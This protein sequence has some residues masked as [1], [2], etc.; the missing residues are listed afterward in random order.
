MRK[1][2][3]YLDTHL[4]EIGIIALSI[5]VPLYPK[6]PL[7]DVPHV[8]VYIRLEDFLVAL[9][10]GIWLIQLA[11]RK[12]SLKTP[13][14][15][16][17]FAY[18]LVGGISLLYAIFVLRPHLANF[19]PNVAVLHYL[20]RIEYMILFFIAAS[21]AEVAANGVLLRVPLNPMLP[22]DDQATVSPFS[23]VTVTMVL[24]KVVET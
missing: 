17:I 2:L 13:L 24:L 14:S 19:F 21:T 22:E 10:V 3:N 4:L 6:L 5:F 7:I 23:F 12:V 16:P 8:W 20:R 15:F 1:L 11:R 9:V 18:W